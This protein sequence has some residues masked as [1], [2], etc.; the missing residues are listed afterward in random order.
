MKT[1]RFGTFTALSVST[2]D[3]YPTGFPATTS[4]F[5][6]PW[7]GSFYGRSQQVVAHCDET[8]PQATCMVQSTSSTATPNIPIQGF[9]DDDGMIHFHVTPLAKSEQ[10]GTLLSGLHRRSP[11]RHL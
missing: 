6:L 1:I 3:R 10:V 2:S 7:T 4:R 9:A 5:H 11:V 8:L